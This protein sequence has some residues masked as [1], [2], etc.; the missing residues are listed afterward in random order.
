MINKHKIKINRS[1]FSN[2]KIKWPKSVE[3]VENGV[4][5][6]PL[7]KNLPPP[8]TQPLD[9][10]IYALHDVSNVDIPRITHLDKPTLANTDPSQ[11]PQSTVHHRRTD[12]VAKNHCLPPAHPRNRSEVRCSGALS[13]GQPS[14][15]ASSWEHINISYL[16]SVKD[17]FSPITVV[18]E[19]RSSEG[20]W[21]LRLE[22]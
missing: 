5:L 2:F 13:R 4:R 15:G 17:Q 18:R 16:R 1:K 10:P 8:P 21:L 9:P 19:N 6:G 20:F 7:G 14:K 12:R 22:Y 3:K 11:S